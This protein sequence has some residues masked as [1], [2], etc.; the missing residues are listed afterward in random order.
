MMVFFMFRSLEKD[1][2]HSTTELRLWSRNA[3]NHLN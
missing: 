3:A 1:A 2:R